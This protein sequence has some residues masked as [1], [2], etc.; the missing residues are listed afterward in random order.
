M[1]PAGHPVS[2]QLVRFCRRLHLA[3][4][5]ARTLS[6]TAR[7]RRRLTSSDGTMRR[8]TGHLPAGTAVT[9]HVTRHASVAGCSSKL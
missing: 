4:P 8:R 5:V 6:S 1:G 7:P 9:R 2:T 3:V